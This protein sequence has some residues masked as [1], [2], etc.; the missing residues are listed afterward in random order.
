MLEFFTDLI[1]PAAIRPCGR[2]S[3]WQKW[4]PGISPGVW[5]RPVRKAD[6]LATLTC[7][8]SRNSGS[9]N[10]LEPS[11]PF[12]RSTGIALPLKL[13]CQVRNVYC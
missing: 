10:L 9:L 3:L 7:L 6:N 12:Q 2:L 1:H 13:R 11:G 8:L 4:V 5:G